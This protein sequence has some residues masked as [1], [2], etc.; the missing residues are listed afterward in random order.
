MK[1]ENV[2]FNIGTDIKNYTNQWFS[3]HEYLK[4]KLLK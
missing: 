1:I 3:F 4:I 2:C